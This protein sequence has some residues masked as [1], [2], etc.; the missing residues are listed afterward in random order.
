MLGI[1]HTAANG[2]FMNC[3]ASTFEL[4]HKRC[5]STV[6]NSKLHIKTTVAQTRQKIH[7]QLLR[8]TGGEARYNMQNPCHFISIFLSRF[9]QRRICIYQST[10]GIM[11]AIVI[12]FLGDLL[13]ILLS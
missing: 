1:V 11:A 12:S 4:I 5:T 9:T 8:T 10:P 7:H 3:D 13:S 2:Q 6:E